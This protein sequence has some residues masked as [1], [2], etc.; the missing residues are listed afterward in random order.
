MATARASTARVGITIG[1]VA[2]I[3]GIATM[4]FGS[5]WVGVGAAVVGLLVL[6]V[7]TGET[8]HG[9]GGQAAGR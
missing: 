1:V 2:F 6:S 4:I 5:F 7:V 9:D 3:A 8:L